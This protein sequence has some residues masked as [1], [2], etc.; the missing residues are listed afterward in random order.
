MYELGSNADLTGAC[1]DGLE[2]GGND[3]GGGGVAGVDCFNGEETGGGGGGGA[4][5]ELGRLPKAF[6]AACIATD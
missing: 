5:G 4:D 3:G 1:E 2:A 6:R